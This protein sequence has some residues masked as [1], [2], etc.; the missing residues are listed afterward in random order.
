[1]ANLPYDLLL[2]DD[3]HA[4]AGPAKE[5]VGELRTTHRAVWVIAVP[6]AEAERLARRFVTAHTSVAITTNPAGDALKDLMITPRGASKLTGVTRLL[7]ILG[8]EKENT[9]GVGDSA[10]D[11]PLFN[12]VGLRIA[13]AQGSSR[14]KVNADVI[15]PSIEHDG[16][17]WV[18]EHLT[19]DN[20]AKTLWRTGHQNY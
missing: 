20:T 5:R 10:N 2:D 14:L 8:V 12:A 13:M 18:L 4:H 17:A 6:V 19:V 11:S 7:E 16:L 3:T 15:A 9:V 1:M